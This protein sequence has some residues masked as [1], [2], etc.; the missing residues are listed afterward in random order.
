MSQTFLRSCCDGKKKYIAHF[1]HEPPALLC[2]N[3]FTDKSLLVGVKKIYNL[4]TQKEI[5]LD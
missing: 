2:E 4:K 5:Q 3:H 1:N